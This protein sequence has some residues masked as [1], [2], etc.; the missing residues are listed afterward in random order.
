MAKRCR[1]A[2]IAE[3]L[4]QERA[5]KEAA[6]AAEQRVNTILNSITDG[7]IAM[8]Q[9]FHVT[10]LNQRAEADISRVTGIPSKELI[11]KTL[12][13]IV[14][15]IAV[16]RFER[17]Y[18][19]AIQDHQAAHF[20]EYYAPQSTWFE[21]NAYPSNGGLS[22]YF[23]DITGRKR[24]EE[25]RNALIRDLDAERKWLRTVIAYSP[26]GT[27]LV[28]GTNGE[29]I[30]A[31][32][33]AEELFGHPLPP[34]GG[35]AQYV[36]E[37]YLPNGT[38]R[39]R[40]ELAVVRALHG[41]TIISEEELLRQPTGQEVRVLASAVPIPEGGQI[42]GAVVVY[43][44][45]TQIRE[46]QRRRIEWTSVVTHDVR[47][48]IQVI[49]GYVGLLERGA[50]QRAIPREQES[51]EHVLVAARNLNKMIGDLLEVSRIEGQRLQ[52]QRQ[53]VDLTGLV[54]DV[55]RR[56]VTTTE[57]HPIRLEAGEPI[58]ASCLDPARIEQVLSNLISNAAKYSY[59]QTEI[60]VSI[61]RQG[62]TAVISVVDHGAGIPPDEMPR[63]FSRFFRTREARAG[64]IGGL[65]LGLYISKGLTEAHGGRI[66]A[67]SIP[68]KTTTFH[69][70][71]PI[72]AP[73]PEPA[74]AA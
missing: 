25:E 13:E 29:R 39:P 23:R 51:L 41:E 30:V 31:N 48:P 46:L 34:E 59:P 65:G 10:Y 40:E 67:E 63:L 8:D 68:G 52:L 56:M 28:E 47:Q 16:T 70:S 12:W 54:R 58:P 11:G 61:K 7:F 26:V 36:G 24:L 5:A 2:P 21:I 22:I 6:L 44:D 15:E 9:H 49:L 74:P 62:D 42:V 64:P 60:L 57:E 71:L 19:Q 43:E 32:R 27:L 53:L 69:V 50:R 55:V 20:E 17:E 66:W 3:R 33:K 35:T 18:R 73:C 72:I 45:I 38:L 4:L 1:R 14:P 37:I